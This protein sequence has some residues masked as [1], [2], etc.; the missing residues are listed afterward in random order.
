MLKSFIAWVRL[1][2]SR[3]S[4]KKPMIAPNVDSAIWCRTSI[5]LETAG[6]KHAAIKR[7]TESE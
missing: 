7:H 2:V 3:R 6:G 5:L 4:Q 1:G